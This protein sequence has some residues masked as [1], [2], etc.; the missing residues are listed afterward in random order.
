MTIFENDFIKVSTTAQDLDYLT[1]IKN[2]TNNKICIHYA[3]PGYNDNYDPILIQPNSWVSLENDDED[4]DWIEAIKNNQIYVVYA[5]TDYY[6]TGFSIMQWNEDCEKIID[7]AERIF[8]EYNL[9]SHD[10]NTNVTNANQLATV[11]E[12]LKKIK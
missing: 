8:N 3:K 4:Y 10:H 1:T 5:E 6:T 12:I 7:E 2:K 11:L 9:Y